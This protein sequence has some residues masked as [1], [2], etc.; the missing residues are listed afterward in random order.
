MS[1]FLYIIL[2]QEMSTF[3]GYFTEIDMLKEK[4]KELEEKL[5]QE[6]E[7]HR[8]IFFRMKAENELLKEEN[9]NLRMEN[10]RVKAESDELLMDNTVMGDELENLKSLLKLSDENAKL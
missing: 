2:L 1:L 6:R 4:I 3:I 10:S 8:D 5:R 7:E 9:N